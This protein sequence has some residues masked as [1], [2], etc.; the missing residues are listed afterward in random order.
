MSHEM[1]LEDVAVYAVGALPAEQADA[2]RAHLR[3]CLLCQEEYRRLAPAVD[4][5]GLQAGLAVAQ[6]SRGLKRRLMHDIAAPRSSPNVLYALLA[7]CIALAIGLG[8]WSGVLEHAQMRQAAEIADLASPQAQRYAVPHGEVIRAGGHLYIALRG[9]AQ[10]PAGK[11][12]QAWTL[13][14]GAKRMVPSST[15]VPARG[16][17]LVRL[18]V[19]ARS[20]GAV[21]MSIE[22]AGGSKQPTSAPAFVVKLE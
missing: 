19:D 13:P 17:V 14:R 10:P 22:P 8:T 15:F 12:Y 3:D 16:S 21:A 5:L 6:P 18:P 1:Q 4:A 20:L 7:A 9:A 11:V 2:V